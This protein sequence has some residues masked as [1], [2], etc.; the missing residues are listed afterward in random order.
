MLRF[1]R[2]RTGRDFSYYKRATIV[3]RVARR[4][5]VNEVDDVAGYLAFLREHQGEAA[6]LLQ[7]LLIS[8]TNF[9]RDR[10]AFHALEAQVPELFRNKTST[11]TIRVWV[12]A[13]ATGEEA[14]S[15]AMLLTEHAQTLDA[16]PA[17]QIFAS[18]LDEEVLAEA[19]I[20]SYPSSI[21]TDLSPER[22]GFS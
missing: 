11:D 6:A 2:A 3:R 19:R 21:S 20:G 10:E 22:F 18:D 15:I 4:M 9:F 7:D 14:Y 17:I 12:P 13:C 1:L 8:V 5:Q 16:P